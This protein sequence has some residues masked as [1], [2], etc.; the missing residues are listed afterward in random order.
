MASIFFSLTLSFLCRRIV[1][2]LVYMSCQCY[3][4]L[5][6][7]FIR[8]IFSHTYKNAFSF[9]WTSRST[10]YNTMAYNFGLWQLFSEKRMY[11]LRNLISSARKIQHFIT[12]I[13]FNRKI[14]STQ[15]RIYIYIF[16]K[17]SIGENIFE[18]NKQKSI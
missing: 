13:Y 11:F 4:L 18:T 14:I 1:I 5:I 17:H 12:K 6:Q 7:S 2:T 10:Q 8:L 15:H 16:W 3:F 9:R